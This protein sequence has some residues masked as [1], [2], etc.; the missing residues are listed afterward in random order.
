[1]VHLLAFALKY[2]TDVPNIVY[3]LYILHDQAFLFFLPF[4]ISTKA[5]SNERSKIFLKTAT[6]DGETMIGRI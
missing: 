2:A 5:T 1:M 4:A 6:N 3:I